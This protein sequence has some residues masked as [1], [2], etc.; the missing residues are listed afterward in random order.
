MYL[1]D[2]MKDSFRTEKCALCVYGVLLGFLG[3]LILLDL[4]C[5]IL[6]HNTSI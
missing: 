2:N 3:L 5:I 4:T 6:L 1:K